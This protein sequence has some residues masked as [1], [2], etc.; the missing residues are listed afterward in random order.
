MAV[1]TAGASG[2]T[3]GPTVETPV[4]ATPQTQST[5]ATPSGGVDPGSP[6]APTAT[7]PASPS[8]ACTLAARFVNET[9]PD[10]TQFAPGEQF[11]KTW[12]LQNV[13]SCTWTAEF[14]LVYV[15]GEQMNGTSPSP[16]GQS[17]QPED[18]IQVFLP[19]TAPA[20][21]GEHQGFW[22][23]SDEGGKQFGLGEDAATPFWV[24]I[25]VV[26]GLPT[27]TAPTTG[28]GLNLGPATTTYAFT[29]NRAPF[30]LGEGDD[31]SFAI[32]DG[33]LRLTAFEP[34]GDLWRVAE[35]SSVDNFALEARF[36]TGPACAGKDSY[37][38]LVRA[39]SQADNIIDSGYVFG[40]NCEGQYRVYVMING[41][42]S[43]IQPW[44]NHASLRPGPNQE[45]VMI[46]RA[47]GDVLQFFGNGTLMY[48]FR[49]TTF[50]SGLW[51]LMIG[52]GGT[53]NFHVELPSI[54]LWDL[55]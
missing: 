31:V 3:P 21:P 10:N 29:D 22:M 52:S 16:I 51:G 43:G 45:N 7:P 24:K 33:A 42:Y 1:S 6:A 41:G 50:S 2:V 37:G 39:P 15:R 53:Q 32:R 5:P 27:S 20:A 12:T 35:R 54:A 14:A 47:L 28:G 4:E 8:A 40:F 11:V 34:A 30:F 46:V 49:D 18:T 48:E 55:P 38:L 17:V 13:G 26:A 23:L 36:R 44:T 25:N 9:I 19:Q